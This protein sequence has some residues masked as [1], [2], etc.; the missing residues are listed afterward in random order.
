MLELEPL[1]PAGGWVG[2]LSEKKK[3]INFSLVKRKNKESILFN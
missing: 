3:R 2:A 1:L